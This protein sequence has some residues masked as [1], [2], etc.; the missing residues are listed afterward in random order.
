MNCMRYL[1]MFKMK[2][3]K[4]K[5]LNKIQMKAFK[6]RKN[7][8]LMR[9]E[10]MPLIMKFKIKPKL[11]KKDNKFIRIPQVINK[12]NRMPKNKQ[13]KKCKIYNK[14]RTNNKMNNLLNSIANPK[15]N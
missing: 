9:K 7:R 12:I 5:F 15:R 13:K 3:W 10:V 8:I 1:I 4:R 6:S 11:K 2:D 14:K